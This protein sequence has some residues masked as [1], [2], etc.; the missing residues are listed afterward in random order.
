VEDRDGM[1]STL[2][3]VITVANDRELAKLVNHLRAL[4]AVMDITRG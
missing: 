1:S 3:F 2:K 4:T